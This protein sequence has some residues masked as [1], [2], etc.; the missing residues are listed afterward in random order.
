MATP[1]SDIKARRA[2]RAA[3]DG[4]VG[5]A[6]CRAWTDDVDAWLAGL[7]AAAVEDGHGGAE[8]IALVAV[9]GYGR[10]EL[11]LQSDIDLVLLHR[12]GSDVRDLADRLW[13]PI[14]DAGLKLGHAVRTTEEALA[15]AADDLDTA[16]ALLDSRLIG[17]DAEVTDDLSV[18]SGRLW[19]KRARRNLAT[20]AQRVR[21]RHRRAGE[22]AFLL[23]PDLK[24]GRGGLRDV[25]TLHWAQAAR[26]I[27]WEGDPDR[28][29]AA[30]D[31]LLAVRV[32][33]H[34]RTGRPG[35]RL[36]LQ[37]QDAVAAALGYDDAD[38]FVRDVS[39][40][41][42]TITWTSDDAWSRIESS[43]TGPLGRL[44]RERAIGPDLVLRDGEVHVT[45]AA[46]VA[47][48]PTLPLRAASA[49]ATHDTR[50]HRSSLERLADVVPDPPLPEPWPDAVRDAFVE[51][52]S[53]GP[54]GIGLYE[55]LDQLGIWE[56][57]LP[58]WSLVRAKPQRNAYHLYTVDR[59]LWEATAQSAGLLGRVGRPDLLVLGALLHDIGKGQP[60]DHTDNGVAL[61][62]TQIGPRLGLPPADVDVLVA[63]CRH[64][65]LLPDVATRRDLDDP[66]TIDAVA[67]AVATP[68]V[69]E[70]LGALTEADSLA[71]GPAAWSAW[72][73]E[74]VGRLVTRTDHVLRGGEPHE[75]ADPFPTAEQRA[76][77]AA[78]EQVIHCDGPVLT[79]VCRDRHGLFNRVAGVLALHGLDVLDAA[80]ATDGPTAL[81]VFRV[82]SSLG[83]VISWQAVVADLERALEG[84]LALRARVAERTRRYGR[85]RAL[86]ATEVETEVCFDVDASAEA[87]VVEV[88]APD[89]VGVLY[90]I[91]R[92]FAD[93][94][95]DIVS[96]KVQTLG[97]LVVDSFYLRDAWGGKLTEPTT[98]AEIERAVL[99]SL[100]EP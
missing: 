33:L 82:E 81:E 21:D 98:L 97:P 79:L 49:A 31:T 23:E 71:T 26:Q 42:R 92:A 63:L 9:G 1:S 47:G 37:E 75:L 91:T 18:R 54:G 50:V 41:A 85:A 89:G 93:L 58:E 95:L 61:I 90:R 74:L 100:L 87:T 14:W 67:A 12:R 4:L 40:A 11:S 73:A 7:F 56:R 15:L 70:L 39:A 80:V 36:L 86:A 60:G 51:L 62:G 2:Q 43:L 83:P 30:Y 88:H 52:L 17:G 10:Q 68:E 72:K 76:Q 5:R 46:D 84:R 27:M 25:H 28:L 77:L 29:H 59:H 78:G 45:A 65:L 99:H 32:E 96:A 57:Y 24:D 3:D 34:R 20:M 44:R 38:D 19:Q 6:L 69:L 66:A 64:H 53:A 13:Y 48:D 55:A 35:D 16:T 94:D 22:V 8:G